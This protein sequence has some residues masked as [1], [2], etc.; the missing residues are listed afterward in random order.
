MWFKTHSYQRQILCLRCPSSPLPRIS[1]RRSCIITYCYTLILQ[2]SYRRS[3]EPQSVVRRKNPNYAPVSAPWNVHPLWCS[4]LKD[5]ILDNS[6]LG[7]CMYRLQSAEWFLELMADQTCVCAGPAAVAP[8]LSFVT[9]PTFQVPIT[10]WEVQMDVTGH[11]NICL[12]CSGTE[13]REVFFHVLTQNMLQRPFVAI[14]RAPRHWLLS[15]CYGLLKMFDA[16]H[17]TWVNECEIRSGFV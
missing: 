11:L 12:P 7:H 9:N 16:A 14:I 17:K 1:Q 10:W 4:V 8:W 2:L 15:H 6:P 5:M 3:V 13:G